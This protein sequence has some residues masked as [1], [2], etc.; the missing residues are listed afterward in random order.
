MVN[1][2]LRSRIL[3]AIIKKFFTLDLIRKKVYFIIIVIQEIL[4]DEG[5][6]KPNQYMKGWS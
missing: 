1:Y 6:V 4:I 2:I 5:K 3:A